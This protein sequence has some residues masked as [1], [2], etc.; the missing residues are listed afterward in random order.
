[1]RPKWD[2]AATSHAGGKILANE[3]KSSV[4]SQLHDIV[5]VCS[6]LTNLGKLINC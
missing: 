6:D 2:V 4:I 5:I 1:M 3:I